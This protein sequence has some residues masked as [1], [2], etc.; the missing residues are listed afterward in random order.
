MEFVQVSCAPFPSKLTEVARFPI[1]KI[2]SGSAKL[3]NARLKRLDDSRGHRFRAM[4]DAIRCLDLHHPQML[5][6][7]STRIS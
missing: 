7:G 4:T 6:R 3:F 5:L 1:P 2:T